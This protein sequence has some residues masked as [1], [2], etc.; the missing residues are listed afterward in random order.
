MPTA[1]EIAPFTDAVDRLAGKTPIASALRTA[2]WEELAIGLRDRAFFSAGVENL[3]TLS[4][5][6]TK[7]GEA[8]QPGIDPERAFMDRGKFVA[9]MRELL[10]APEGDSDE[11]TD[12]AS[13]RR[14][15]LIHDFQTEDAIEGARWKAA[16]DPDLLDAFPAQ[17]LIR[18]E[19]RQEPRDW[20]ARWSEA[21]GRFFGGRMIARKDDPIWERISRFGRPWP[22]F[23]FG[24]GMGLQDIEREEAIALG[25]I[26]DDDEVAS[27]DVAFN[28]QLE[29]SLPPG[30]ESLLE[31]FQEIFG[32]QVEIRDGK[33]RWKGAA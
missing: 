16:Q 22:P 23:D 25:L 8:L 6:Q 18:V 1:L 19:G 28:D 32:D 13:R 20:A 4:A 5:M 29:A 15:E 17:E 24:S 27:Q 7:L 26:Q 30:S 9:E 3:R 14:L 31:G 12:L 10:G 2:E 33:I 21:G 11:L